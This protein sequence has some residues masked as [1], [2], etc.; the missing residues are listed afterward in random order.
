MNGV[1]DEFGLVGDD[2]ILHVPGPQDVILDHFQ[3]SCDGIGHGDRV[4]VRSPVDGRFNAFS[5]VDARDD[6]AFFIAAE[7]IRHAAQGDLDVASFFDDDV[8]DLFDGLELING[9]DQK[10][11]VFLLEN[12]GREID[13]FLSQAVGNG[14]Y[15]DVKKAEFLF[16][17]VDVDLVLQASGYGAS[18]NT[19]YTFECLLD[20]SLG[21]VANISQ[22]SV[23]SQTELHDG[24]LVGVVPEDDWFGG[25]DRKAQKVQLFPEFQGGEVHV[26]VPGELDRYLGELCTGN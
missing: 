23:A 8:F 16:I 22:I 7:H 21:D 9:P 13:V 2:Q 12:P 15:G 25:S 4:G 19:L 3:P 24:F 14:R 1:L 6:F 5:A 11:A 18:G 26:G 17:D 20:F 10:L